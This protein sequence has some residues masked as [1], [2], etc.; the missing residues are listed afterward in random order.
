MDFIGNEI[1]LRKT[2]LFL[3]PNYNGKTF[4]PGTIVF[5]K[6]DGEVLTNKKRILEFQ[7]LVD[8]NT[9]TFESY[10][11]I[12]TDFTFL[13]WS[14]IDLSKYTKGSALP[15]IDKEK[16]LSTKFA[17]P[18]LSTQRRITMKVKSTFEVV[19]SFY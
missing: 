5:P 18:S 2:N 3:L 13:I 10:S 11:F 8:L 12:S 15:T 17:I 4:S 9:G 7:S 6:N 16:L 19:D 14:S 1:F